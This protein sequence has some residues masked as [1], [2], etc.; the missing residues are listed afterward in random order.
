[1]H[2]EPP[3][4]E[5]A[6]TMVDFIHR[7]PEV[8]HFKDGYLTWNSWMPATTYF[9]RLPGV[10]NIETTPGTSTTFHWRLLS[11]NV[12][13]FK[14]K[15]RVPYL[16]QQLDHY[17]VLLSGLQETRKN[18]GEIF[19]STHFRFIATAEKGV[20]G[21]ELWVSTTLPYHTQDNQE[22]YFERRQFQTVHTD[23]Q[24]LVVDC[25][26]PIW[27]LTFAV[28]H[29]PHRGKGN[30]H[31]SDWWTYLEKFSH[32]IAL[33]VIASFSL[34]PTPSRQRTNRMLVKT[35][36]LSQIFAEKLSMP[37]SGRR[38]FSCLLHTLTC[39]PDYM[40]LGRPTMDMDKRGLTYCSTLDLVQ[41][42]GPKSSQHTYRFGSCRT[43]A[44]CC[45]GFAHRT[46][47]SDIDQ[48]E[49]TQV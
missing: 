41:P 1:M 8:P 30:S 32:T 13:S 14:D 23:P 48:K 4:I 6:W 17:G 38:T 35:Q 27:K 15:A 39:I 44:Q 16:R 28:A 21:C 46:D 47:Y 26:L 18:Y 24:L 10:Y 37:A 36:I 49:N 33:D 12:G 45:T 11:Y 9:D 20:G 40:I 5:W 34:T 7:A 22:L 42:R 2:G 25:D 19:D 43:G 29:A 31:V 3:L